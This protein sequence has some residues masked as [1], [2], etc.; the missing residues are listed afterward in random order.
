M[1]ATLEEAQL[2]IE[3]LRIELQ[4]LKLKNQ[5]LLRKLYGRSS[6]KIAVE[7]GQ[8]IFEGLLPPPTPVVEEV[9]SALA[10]PESKPPVRRR[11]RQPL[12]E[13]VR[14]ET[15]PLD[16]PEAER[17]CECCG[18]AK[19]R[20]G[21]QVTEEL[22]HIPATLVRRLLVRGK[23]ACRCG[24]GAVAQAPL[25]P[26]PIEKGRPGPGLLAHVTLSKYVD[27]LPLYRQQEMFARLGVEISRQRLGDW[28]GAIA[29]W[30]QPVARLMK[31]NLLAGD[32]LQ[33]DETPV[34]V[35]DPEIRGKCA[36]GYLWV[37]S[38]PGCDVI[39]EFHRHRNLDAA[40][41]LLKGFKG[42]IQT[43]AYAVYAAYVR[44][45]P[46][47]ARLGCLA[48]ARREFFEARAEDR[49][50]ADTILTQIGAL[51]T[52]ERAARERG[53]DPPG[54]M[55]LR[56]EHAPPIWAD[57]HPQLEALQGR[58]LPQSGLGK[59][60]AYMLAEWT[61]LQGYLRDGRF[62]I[63][64]NLCENAIR[65]TALGKKNWLFLGHPEAAWRSAVI[66]SLVVSCRRRGLEPYAYLRDVLTR[67]PAMKQQDLPELI[68]ARWKPA[69]AD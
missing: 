9:V 25:P 66:Y 36:Q 6:E 18:R 12:P 58:C 67:L 1:P 69:S 54:R 11:G 13:H 3:R 26:R 4:R 22:E 52:I 42:T 34:R 64:N 41:A 5:D 61:A 56:L 15:I 7:D 48:H 24:Q 16:P 51:Y 49:A 57:L 31:Q 33:V 59:A 37:A 50:A 46:E 10:A 44:K 28:I 68:P 60:A 39:F 53:L 45:Y 30:L 27:H 20:I 62:E 17:V 8:M 21:E 43:D 40:E 55:A 23:Y 32:Y 2:T 29:E 47:V 14:T 65:P 35:Q 38:A 63:D 19:E